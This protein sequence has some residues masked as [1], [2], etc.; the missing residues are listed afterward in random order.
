MGA[1]GYDIWENDLACD[2]KGD[3]EEA[4]EE[5]GNK[6]DAVKHIFNKWDKKD[7][8]VEAI[9]AL[10][11]IQI[12]YGIFVSYHNIL[13]SILICDKDYYTNIY[14]IPESRKEALN[15]FKAKIVNHEF[16]V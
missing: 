16:T 8:S 10:T 5:C 9:L 2:I 3:L 4:I 14:D 13:K 11:D 6:Y 15:R 1:W 12:E 7:A